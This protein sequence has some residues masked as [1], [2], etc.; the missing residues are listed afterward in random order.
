M[1]RR[2]RR[3]HK[4]LLAL[5][6][7][8]IFG[9]G[10]ASIAV[11]ALLWPVGRLDSIWRLNPEAHTAFLAMGRWAVAIMAVVAAACGLAA[12]GLWKRARWP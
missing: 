2:V 7:F 10:M 3:L 9:A 11:I 1:P 6:C 5:T 8:F 4:G 12:L